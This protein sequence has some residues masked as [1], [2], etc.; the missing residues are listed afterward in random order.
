MVGVVVVWLGVVAVVLRLAAL[1]PDDHGKVFVVFSPA[2]A[3]AAAF[4][5]I[6]GAGGQ[7]LRPVVGNWGWIAHGDG[8]GFVGRLQRAGAL[9]AFRGAP[10]GLS[11]AGCFAWA[12][13]R[14]V[15]HDPFA[16]ALEA[17]AAGDS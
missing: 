15:P 2:T 10:V 16:R 8:A 9:A 6:V 14:P 3:S 12:A 17:R 4:D 13:D 7:P 11:L 5:A 1:G